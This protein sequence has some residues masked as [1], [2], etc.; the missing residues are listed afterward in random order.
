MTPDSHEK[1]E[2]AIDRTLRILPPRRAPFALEQRVRAEIARRAARPWWRRSFAHWPGPVQVGFVA[3]SALAVYAVLALGGAV[4]VPA[5]G[6]FAGPLAWVEGGLA[7]GRG[8]VGVCETVARSL[9][10]LLLY[11]GLAFCAAVYAGIVGLGAA[12]WRNLQAA[13]R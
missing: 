6:A 10:P 12:A 8:I 9:P 1:L 5:V 7:A 2:Q 3:V 11:G 4:P 13:G